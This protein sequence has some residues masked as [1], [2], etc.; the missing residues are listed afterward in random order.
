MNTL[1]RRLSTDDDIYHTFMNAVVGKLI[2]DPARR[3]A[4]AMPEEFGL[5][6]CNRRKRNLFD[7]APVFVEIAREFGIRDG[8]AAYALLCLMI[9]ETSERR[10]DLRLIDAKSPSPIYFDVLGLVCPP[11]SSS[12]LVAAARATLEVPSNAAC[13]SICAELLEEAGRH[14]DI[15]H[16]FWIN[17]PT[18]RRAYDDG[19]IRILVSSYRDTILGFVTYENNTISIMEIFETYRAVGFGRLMVK[20]IADRDGIT[21]VKGILPEAAGFWSRMPVEVE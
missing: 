2:D 15:H 16:G 3:Y 21:R 7:M 17:I 1:E 10:W 13:L 19:N 18:I 8:D 11:R 5:R 14:R 6:F 4:E 12:R 20:C 9:T